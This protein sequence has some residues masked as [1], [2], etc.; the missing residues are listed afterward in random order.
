MKR[1]I[2][3]ILNGLN[4]V[5]NA[6]FAGHANHRSNAAP[7]ELIEY[8]CLQKVQ[9]ILRYLKSMWISYQ[10]QDT[11]VEW[12]FTQIYSKKK[13]NNFCLSYIKEY[14]SQ[15]KMLKL[16]H[17]FC[18]F[19]EI[20]SSMQASPFAFAILFLRAFASPVTQN[21]SRFEWLVIS[22][23]A[24]HSKTSL[25][26]VWIPKPTSTKPVNIG[27]TINLVKRL[28]HDAGAVQITEH[29]VA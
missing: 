18:R 15:G 20:I 13:L 6:T 3:I 17:I 19:I 11:N 7:F 16:Y 27:R 4:R 12:I 5:F 14:F 21:S 29:A 28:I 23:D 9:C 25:N 8:G 2:Q 24:R 26:V 1:N 22:S 10:S